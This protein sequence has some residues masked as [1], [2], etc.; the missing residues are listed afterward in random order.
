MIVWLARSPGPP[1]LLR[2][3]G[4]H[5]RRTR[6]NLRRIAANVRYD[7][8]MDS[9]TYELRRFRA[10]RRDAEYFAASLPAGGTHL[11]LSSITDLRS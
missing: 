4:L 2:T 10:D 6:H 1:A 8:V 11:P 7:M 9:F 3:H 5:A